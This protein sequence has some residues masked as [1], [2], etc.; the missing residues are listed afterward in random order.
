MSLIDSGV[1]ST[2]TSFLRHGPTPGASAVL[3]ISRMLA[4]G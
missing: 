2:S 3:P 1:P 4:I